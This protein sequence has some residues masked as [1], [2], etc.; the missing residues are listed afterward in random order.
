M[1]Q[2]P[3]DVQQALDLNMPPNASDNLIT[4]GSCPTCTY[5]PQEVQEG[6]WA[7][8]R[9]HQKDIWFTLKGFFE[10]FTS[11]GRA[12]LEVRAFGAELKVE[13]KSIKD[14]RGQTE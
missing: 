7:H 10:L 4:G 8:E 3:A 11:K 6:V 2:V 14:F 9:Q 5:Y 1:G 13:K 12:E